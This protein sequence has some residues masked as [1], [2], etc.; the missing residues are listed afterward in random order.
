MMEIERENQFKADEEDVNDLFYRVFEYRNSAKFRKLLNFC[1]HFRRLSPFNAMLLAVQRPGCEFALTANRWSRNYGRVPKSDARPLIIIRPFGPVEYLFDVADTEPLDP[2]HDR[3]PEG[4]SGAYKYRQQVDPDTFKQLKMNLPLWGIKFDDMLTGG[5]YNGK[6]QMAESVDGKVTFYS[7]P[8]S[9]VKLPAGWRAAY[10]I[11]TKSG[12]DDTAKFGTI[13][14][15]LGHLFCHHL[16]SGY[17][18]RWPDKLNRLDLPK[19]QEEFEAETI[20]WLVA[21]RIGLEIPSSYEYLAGYLND[22]PNGKQI[23]MFDF[24]T[25]FQAASEV[26]KLL[27][28]CNFKDGWLWEY[29][30]ALQDEYRRLNP[31]VKTKQGEF[32]F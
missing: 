16:P 18:R 26:E 20:A 17:S 21:H 7:K 12:M 22:G 28:P 3:V 5:G 19:N 32:E 4:L 2:N 8:K 25:V 30:P 27:R 11:K 23:P 15:E 10:T 6:L 24:Y 31:P 9:K 13:L 1:V 29:T 14:H